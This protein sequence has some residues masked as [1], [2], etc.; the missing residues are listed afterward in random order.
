M[1]EK[2]FIYKLGIQSGNLQTIELLP[3]SKEA[4]YSKIELLIDTQSKQIKSLKQFGENTTSSEYTIH[5]FSPVMIEDKSFIVSESDF[6][7]FDVIDL[8]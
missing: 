8:R 7:N 1:Y 4:D 5:T 2:G 6:P 3:E